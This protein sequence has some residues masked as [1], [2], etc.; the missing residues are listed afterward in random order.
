MYKNKIVIELVGFDYINHGSILMLESVIKGLNTKN[1]IFCNSPSID[2]P[3]EKNSKYNILYLFNFSGFYTLLSFI[4]PILFKKLL[5]KFSIISVYDVDYIIDISGFTYSSVWG[6]KPFINLLSI[7]IRSYATRVKLI[8][9]PQAF[10]PFS[11]FHSLIFKILCKRS[12]IVY[13]RDKISFNHII[14]ATG[15][16]NYNNIKLYPDFTCILKKKGI[17]SKDGNV[18]YI[19]PNYRLVDKFGIGLNELVEFYNKII[20]SHSNYKFKIIYFEK[21]DQLYFK[22]CF[23]DLD[24]YGFE[25]MNNDLIFDNCRI[26]IGSRFHAIVSCLNLTIPVIGISWSHKYHE[27]FREYDISEFCHNTLNNDL[28]INQIYSLNDNNKLSEIKQKLKC[29]NDY[30]LTKVNSLFDDLNDSISFTN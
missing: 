4:V 19:N 3:I 22:N 7:L 9:L 10:G 8:L 15:K 17:S 1:C 18:I 12:N 21:N 5:N 13:V 29:I 6:N 16:S 2:R 30:N 24:R 11:K 20:V 25:E 26:M 23:N 27:L 28:V 14:K